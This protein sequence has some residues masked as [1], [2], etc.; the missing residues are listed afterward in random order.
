MSLGRRVVTRLH[1]T[2]IAITG[3]FERGPNDVY[4]L[5]WRPQNDPN[6]IRG[7]VLIVA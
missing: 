6:V 2:K 5:F 7:L 4:L 1:A 3:I